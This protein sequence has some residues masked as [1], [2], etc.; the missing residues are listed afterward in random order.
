MGK[1][2]GQIQLVAEGKLDKF[3][4]GNPNITAYKAVY[5]RYTR[6]AIESQQI[7]YEGTADFGK[8]LVFNINRS[9]GDLL[10]PLFLQVDLPEITYTNNTVA[11]WVNSIGHALIQEISLEIGEEEVDKQTGEWME[12]WTQHSIPAGKREAFNKMIGRVD[13]YAAP[14]LKGPQSLIIPLH[15]WFCKDSEN[16][17][18]LVA[19]Q[20]SQIRLVLT[21]RPLSQLIAPD[22]TSPSPP[23]SSTDILCPPPFNPTNISGLALWGDFVFVETDERRRFVSAT[24]EYIIEQT[25]YTQP[26]SISPLVTS[27]QVGLEFNHCIKELFWYVRPDRLEGYNEWMNF[28]TLGE[29]EVGTRTQ[30]LSDAILQ[31]DGQ[32]RFATRNAD[33]FRIVQPFQRHSYVPFDRYIYNYSF[34][35]Q[36]ES[37]Q[38]EGSVNVTYINS[39]VFTFNINN[40]VSP[41]WSTTRVYGRNYNILRIIEGIAGVLFRA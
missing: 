26:V 7:Y 32:D 30:L 10:G 9:G 35:L 1:G 4:N 14:N 21:I 18:P 24:H 38:P 28:S 8:K 17:L 15:F 12:I 34:A 31:F 29:S 23:S 36:P 11:S 19:I 27:I 41:G 5:K 39:V 22:T 13:G 16:Y 40:N 25:Q 20:H 2:G 3:L 37:T 6:F 33:Y